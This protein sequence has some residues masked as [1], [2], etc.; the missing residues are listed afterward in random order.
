MGKQL[1]QKLAMVAGLMALGALGGCNNAKSPDAVSGD[2]AS[3]QQTA[4]ENVADA[5]KDAAKD[6]AD[7][8][9]KS[10][11]QNKDTIETEAKGAYDV[12][13]ARAGGDHKVALQKC[14]AL[15]GDAQKNCKDRADA[16]YDAA[17]ANSKATE[18]AQK[19]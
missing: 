4:N 17:K 3:A 8:L 16:D 10:A 2:V 11:D 19:Q 5:Q 15:A 7:A 9:A 13:V 18:T 12:A 6:N 1:T 14:E